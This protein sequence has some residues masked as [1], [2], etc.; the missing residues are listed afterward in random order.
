MSEGGTR[1]IGVLTS[2]GYSQGID[3]AV[4]AVV[5]T[6]IHFGAEP[7]AISEGYEGLLRG[8]SHIRRFEWGDVGGILHEGCTVSRRSRPTMYGAP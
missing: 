1:R 6:A 4:R 7:Y 3:A 2:G 8:A 5:R